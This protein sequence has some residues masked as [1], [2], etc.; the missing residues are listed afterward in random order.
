MKRIA[1]LAVL[2]FFGGSIGA[3][4]GEADLRSTALVDG[5]K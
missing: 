5:A 3:Q 4:A 2:I 1:V